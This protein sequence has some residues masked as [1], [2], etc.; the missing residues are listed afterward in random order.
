MKPKNKN[1]S[2]AGAEET[3]RQERSD[4]PGPD[5]GNSGDAPRGKDPTKYVFLVFGL[6]IAM[7]ALVFLVRSTR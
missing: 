2:I 5:A 3:Q 6:L 7:L 4:A 1:K